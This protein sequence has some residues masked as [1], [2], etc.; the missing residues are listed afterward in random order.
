MSSTKGWLLIAIGGLVILLVAGAIAARAFLL[1]FERKPPPAAPTAWLDPL[2]QVKVDEVK[3][4]LALL[5]L[6]DATDLE[7][8]NHALAEGELENAYAAIV[9]STA[10]SDRQRAGSLL[11]LA[12][13]Y[14]EAGERAKAKLC[15]QQVNAIATLGPKL[16]DFV[17]AETYLQI[18]QGLAKRGEEDD[19]LFNYDQAYTLALH[20]PHLKEPH[21]AYILDELAGAYAALDEEE[22]CSQCLKRAAEARRFPVEPKASPSTPPSPPQILVERAPPQLEIDAARAQ[23]VS[24]IQ[25]LR[26]NPGDMP[27]DLV[28]DLAQALRAED[29]ARLKSYEAQLAKAVRTATKVAL[30]QARID[31]L[32]IK[33]RVA[34]RGYGLSIVPEWEAQLTQIR[35]DLSAAYEGLYLLCSEQVIALPQADDIGRAWVDLIKE[36]IEMGRLGLYPDYP[37]RQLITRLRG[38]TARLVAT[39]GEGL[40]YVDVLPRDGA[41]VFILTTGGYR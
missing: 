23:R 10:L 11:L 36:E 28:D 17:R 3:P 12:Q 32:T 21:K 7:A 27:S 37:E 24:A 19:A 8:V 34:S 18:G 38:A 20:S 22:K 40:L 35:S 16:P 6:A 15:Y 31:W 33:Y 29:E 4:S 5:S 26:A 1:L 9:F 2:S 25:S 30:A 13:G 14:A 39:Q 41:N